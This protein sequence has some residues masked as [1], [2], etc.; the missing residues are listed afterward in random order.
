MTPLSPLAGS[1]GVAT[2]PPVASSSGAVASA[3]G[4][5]SCRYPQRRPPWLAGAGRGSDCRHYRRLA[6][7]ASTTKHQYDP[8]VHVHTTTI[9]PP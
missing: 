4:E 6:T 5:A 2:V 7:S 1:A 9:S 8:N 3:A